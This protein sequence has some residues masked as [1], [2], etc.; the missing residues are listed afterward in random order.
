MYEEPEEPTPEEIPE[1]P[2]SIEEVEEV[3]PPRGT[4]AFMG[5]TFKRHH[6]LN[7]FSEFI[8]IQNSSEYFSY[9]SDKLKVYYYW[10]LSFV[11]LPHPQLFLL[12]IQ[13]N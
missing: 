12:Q 7:F 2:P 4:A 8:S 13:Y 6:V 9:I 11:S 10:H 3:V 1:E 5:W